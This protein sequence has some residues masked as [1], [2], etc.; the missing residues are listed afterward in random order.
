MAHEF[1][2]SPVPCA[3]HTAGRIF[4][5]TTEEVGG[6]FLFKYQS[7]ALV[8]GVHVC[9]RAERRGVRVRSLRTWAESESQSVRSRGDFWQRLS[10]RSQLAPR[11]F[12]RAPATQPFGSR[13]AGATCMSNRR[14]S[15]ASERLQFLARHANL[16][17]P[18]ANLP[19][20]FARVSHTSTCTLFF[21]NS[22]QFAKLS[23]L[24][25]LCRRCFCCKRHFS[26]ESI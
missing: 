7:L 18:A 8:S 21:C 1:A 15:E 3:A 4:G 11:S 12:T 6:E 19:A 26:D 17:F 9:E 20:H 14:T 16:I 10:Q 2:M 24:R 23:L 5:V 22:P 25:L 13:A